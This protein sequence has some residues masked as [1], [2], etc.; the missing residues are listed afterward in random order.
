MYMYNF[1]DYLITGSDDTYVFGI[2]QLSNF[3]YDSLSFSG[4]V[5]EIYIYIFSKWDRYA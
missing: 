2:S 1:Y 4:I 3:C 5:I